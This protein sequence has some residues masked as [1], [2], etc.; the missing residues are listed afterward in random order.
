MI[1]I[2]F[3][4]DA[5]MDIRADYISK[6]KIGKSDEVALQEIMK[7][8]KDD[9][10]DVDVKYDL[11]YGLADVL[12]EM[13]RLT[14][15][16]KDKTIELIGMEQNSEHY[17]IKD[18]QGRYNAL[19]IFKSK[20]QSEMPKRKKVSVHKPHITGWTEGDIYTFT[21]KKTIKGYEEY[22]GWYVLFYINKI[23]LDDWKV[24][25][26]KD[27][28]AE[29]Y[30][31][32]RKEKPTEIKDLYDSKNICFYSGREGNRYRVNIFET[33]KKNRPKDI[34]F[35]GACKD[36]QYPQNDVIESGCFYWNGKLH[37][38]DILVGYERQ[39][40][41]EINHKYF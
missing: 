26:I 12:W 30:F 32:L 24:E 13:G 39:I 14:D 22:V 41:Y 9:M 23:R 8:Y 7:E 27:E 17:S 38:R 29:A 1:N 40:E 15:D 16:F 28:V 10:E 11:I 21:I 4:T 6:L 35:V 36:F 2:L 34:E 31:F 37:E 5:S 19:D 20:L 25:G 33:S 3:Q 18:K